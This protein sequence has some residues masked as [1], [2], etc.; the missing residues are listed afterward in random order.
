MS[1]QETTLDC[2]PPGAVASV[3]RV[4]GEDQ[5]ARRLGDLG[6]W[7]GT[8]VEVVRRAPLGDPTQYGLRGYRLALRRVEARRVVV[9]PGQ[10]P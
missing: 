1:H 4:E 10:V 9:R 6:F 5:I 7:A 8:L 3:V 2:L